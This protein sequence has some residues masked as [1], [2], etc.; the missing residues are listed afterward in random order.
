M[1]NL[2]IYTSEEY[3]EKGKI[4]FFSGVASSLQVL[5]LGSSLDLANEIL[6]SLL[7][8]REEFLDY[9]RTSD[10]RVDHDILK[11]LTQ[12]P[13]CMRNEMMGECDCEE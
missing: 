3:H 8:E 12:T 9:L 1:S 4:G 10:C 6:D 7:G 2:Y 5:H 13:C 11:W